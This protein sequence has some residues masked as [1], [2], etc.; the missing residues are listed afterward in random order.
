MHKDIQKII[1][2]EEKIQSRIKQLAKKINNDYKNKNLLLVV[3][4]RGAALF[5]ADLSRQIR[6]PHWIDFIVATR[7]GYYDTPRGEVKLIKDLD[8][9]IYNKD[10][11]IIEDIIDNGTTIHYIM[12]HLKQRKPK[13]LKICSLFDK[14]YHRRIKI[15]INYCGFKVPDKFVVGYGLDYKQRYRNFPYLAVLKPEI[16]SRV[17][18]S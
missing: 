5:L 4:L 13:S 14:P 2:T 12:K 9:P 18:F 7:Y 8:Q 15:K 10:I 17:K 3:I 11:L 16:H 1:F 6:I